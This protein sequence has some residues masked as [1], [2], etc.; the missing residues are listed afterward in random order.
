MQTDTKHVMAGESQW[1]EDSNIWEHLKARHKPFFVL[2]PMDDVTDTVFRQ[3]VIEAAA[4]DITMTEFANT[5]GFVSPGGH[6]SV[7]RKLHVNKSE[8]TLKTPLI[9]QIWGATPQ[10]YHDTTAALVKSGNFAGIDINMGCPEKGIVKRGCCGGL[11]DRP[12]VAADIIAATKAAAGDLPVSV[13]TRI[14]LR[15]I[16]TERWISH[17]LRQNVAAL[18]V[19]G[20]TVKEMSK[21]PAHWD[22]IAKAVQLRNELAPDT[23]LIGNGDVIDRADGTRLAAESGTDGI[24]IGRGIFHNLFAFADGTPDQSQARRYDIMH[25]HIELYAQTWGSDKS[26]EPLKKFFKIYVNGF[27]GASERRQRLMATKSYDEA[28]QIVESWQAAL[29]ESPLQ[30]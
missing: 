12:E 18:T 19:H 11:I 8:Q 7:A 26:F 20:R 28:L 25:K 24:M 10:N 1:T 21:V 22:E 15:T 23:V 13:K 9:A 16:E 27:A 17:I 4:P 3:I 6:S 5:D 2:A 14:G 29:R 30:V